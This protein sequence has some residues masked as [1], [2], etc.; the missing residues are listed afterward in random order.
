MINPAEENA[1]QRGK[2]ISP[3]KTCPF[4]SCPNPSSPLY[5]DPRKKFK[6]PSEG[7][8]MTTRRTVLN[9]EQLGARV[10]PALQQRLRPP[11][12]PHRMYRRQPFRR[13]RGR[14]GLAKAAIPSPRTIQPKPRRTRFKARRTTV[15]HGFFAI[16][17]S[18]TTVGSKSGQATG[19]IKLSDPRGT[20]TL[21]LTGATAVGQFRTANELLL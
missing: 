13:L 3:T 20:L 6:P 4:F 11:R 12:L 10:L 2:T 5:A 18:V 1:A 9:V 7:Q 17:G 19:T 8:N 15:S 16:S 21:S 14:P